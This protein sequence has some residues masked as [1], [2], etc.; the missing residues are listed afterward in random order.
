[1]EIKDYLKVLGKRAWL[2][3]M[4]PAVAGVVAGLIAVQQPQAFRTTA[5]LQLPHDVNSSP[6]EVAQLVA[7]FKAAANNPTVQS[8]VS[9]DTGLTLQ[10][11]RHLNI[12]QVGDSS[13]L[14]LGYQTKA[15][16][17]AAAKAVILGISS[18]ALNYLEAPETSS[19]QSEIDSVNAKIKTAQDTI[20]SA[21]TQ[22]VA[23]YNDVKS[24]SPA[25]DV[26]QLKQERSNLFQQMVLA[27]AGGETAKAAQLQ[28]VIAAEDQ[29]IIALQQALPKVEILQGQIADAQKTQTDAQTERDAAVAKLATLSAIPDLT[30]SAEGTPVVRKTR[31]VKTAAAAVVA[32]FPIAVGVVLLL[33]A[34]Q[35]R[36]Q[37]R[38]PRPTRAEL[39]AQAD[40]DLEPTAADVP[41]PVASTTATTPVDPLVPARAAQPEPADEPVHQV[42]AVPAMAAVAATGLAVDEYESDEDEDEDEA[43]ADADADDLDADVEDATDDLEAEE[44]AD[45]PDAE[46]AAIGELDDEEED[47]A[48]DAELDDAALAD[49]DEE[50]DEDLDLVTT[51][52]LAAVDDLAVDD[53][54]AGVDDLEAEDAADLDDEDLDDE[55]LDDAE[56]DDELDD[57]VDATVASR[58]RMYDAD[59]DDD[60]TVDGDQAATN[61]H[62][63]V[64]ARVPA[65]DEDFDGDDEA[66]ADR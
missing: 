11:I 2:L 29:Q 45:G 63:R 3:I 10:Q 25:D 23:I 58:R 65:A 51:V 20:D 61:G 43:E 66:G 4:I 31:V 59:I 28:T 16:D 56:L 50:E 38:P 15:K 62:G 17:P 6:A 34:L 35:K 52:P 33:D 48:V 13:Q 39:R 37:N 32:G 40:D 41:M 18:G 26:K 7:D 24:S 54:L 21:N 46:L 49:L 57:D 36:R 5:T 55:D 14:T 53:D 42:A 60:L 8:K 19:T 12:T 9:K 44:D 1:V 30:F 27:Q 22:L 64:W 47:D